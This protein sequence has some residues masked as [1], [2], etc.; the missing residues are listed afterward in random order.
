M[1]ACVRR[2][3]A[4]L[5]ITLLGPAARS[6]PIDDGW[7]YRRPI[8]VIWDDQKASGTE[9]AAAEFY[10]AGHHKPN[11]EDVK[12]ATGDGRPVSSRVIMVG[13]GDRVRLLFQLQKKE[14]KYF[15][16]FGDRNP[17]TTSPATTPATN[18][19]SKPAQELK[20]TTGL[21]LEMKQWTGG[22]VD[23][24]EQ[25]E[26]SWQRSEPVIGGAML[27][28]PFLGINPFGEQQQ[29]I[30]RITA[31]IFAP[32][33]GDY[34][35]AMT[36][37]DRGA[38]Y[39][40]DKP[41][42]FASTGPADVRHRASIRLSRGRH[43]FLLY[44]VNAAG[45]GRFTVAWKRPDTK[46]FDVIPRE[47]F[48]ILFQGSAGALE[49]FR[50]PLTAD[51]AVNHLGECFYASGYSHR[52]GFSARQPKMGQ[53]SFS[54]DFGDGQT[55]TLPDP[56]HVYFLDGV[57]PVMLTVRIGSNSDTQSTKIAVSRDYDQI[58]K[59]PTDEPPA[60]ARLADVYDVPKI[61][62]V[63]LPR[64]VQLQQRAGKVVPMLAAAMRLAAESKHPDPDS[65]MTA[66]QEATREALAQTNSDAAVELWAK[67]PSDSDLQP[68]AVKQYSQLLLWRAADFPKALQVLQPFASGDDVK[69]RRLYAEALVLNGKMPEGAKL[70]S[71]L[72]VEGL[73]ERQSAL[74]GAS[75]RTIESYIREGDWEAG[76]DEWENWQA[77]YPI[78]FLEG[79]SVLLKTRL[80]EIK[81][82]PQAAA[83]LAE[84]FAAAVP[85]SSY[86][87]QLL[88]RASKLLAQSDAAKSQALRKLLKER[89]PED[90]LS[91]GGT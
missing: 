38:L 75:A 70:L 60:Q 41:L 89:Y 87:P 58:T 20:V 88:D 78:D 63:A 3:A 22:V 19:T 48:G 72:P 33:D 82:A 4:M 81:K 21:L 43:S 83:K 40:D 77:R 53:A 71:A 85:N 49:E 30:S 54:W 76:E 23:T 39:I 24:F 66:L 7:T 91:Q 14:R 17:P 2:G 55:S 5:L 9:L 86:A 52:Y 57:Y 37:D 12:M 80:M 11:G 32:V 6:G 45:D 90:P 34:T 51:F 26:A 36:V 50:K 44:H 18:S 67:A 29:T 64:A 47:S 28:T 27:A 1:P 65:A 15:A 73:P 56:Q 79:Y 74:S 84:A 61:P 46:G 13:P 8:E 68:R 10:T 25:V 42:V 59:P 16:Y 31:S 35:F 62:I 69:L